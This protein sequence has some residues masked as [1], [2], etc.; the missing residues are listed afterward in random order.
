MCFK[1]V[2]TRESQVLRAESLTEN[3][4][5]QNLHPVVGLLRG[6][7]RG[8]RRSAK[9]GPTVCK[10]CVSTVNMSTVNTTGGRRQFVDH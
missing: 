7:L 9:T 10:L 8:R 5:P 1:S 4:P 3:D 6:L 2:G